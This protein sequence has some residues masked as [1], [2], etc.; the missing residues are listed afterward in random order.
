MFQTGTLPTSLLLVVEIVPLMGIGAFVTL[1]ASIRFTPMLACSS[2]C[3]ITTAFC[4]VAIAFLTRRSLLATT[5]VTSSID[6]IDLG[7][8]RSRTCLRHCS[9]MQ[10]IRFSDQHLQIVLRCELCRRH[11]HHMGHAEVADAKAR[12]ML[13]RNHCPHHFRKCAHLQQGIW[14][15]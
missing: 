6:H 12:L 4:I 1:E 3:T 13:L 7:V 5:L 14:N 15:L 10:V 2:S 8:A 11:I 9:M